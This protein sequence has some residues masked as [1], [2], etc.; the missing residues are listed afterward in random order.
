MSSERFSVS[1]EGY[2]AK[3][4][5][6]VYL[7]DAISQ[8]LDHKEDNPKV[9]PAKFFHDYFTSIHQGNHTLFR[10]YSFIRSTAHNRSSFTRTFW[11]CYKHIGKNGDLL[12]V[13]EYHSLLCL[14]CPDFPFDLVQK[15]ARIIL[16]DDAMDCLMSFSDFLYAFQLQFYYEEFL[17]DC[18]KIY[19][20]LMQATR[21]PRETVVVPSSSSSPRQKKQ[22]TPLPPPE[23]SPEGV[24]CLQFYE[25]LL[26][27]CS[28]TDCSH[29]KT[30]SLKDILHNSNRVSFYGFLMALAKNESVNACIGVLPTK[31]AIMD[32]T[33]P[34]H[35]VPI[36]TPRSKS[37][38]PVLGGRTPRHIKH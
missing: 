24:D 26:Q 35:I 6:L 27:L 37:A 5:V 23:Q 2:L 17:Q 3:H 29:P 31:A 16:M 1:A 8:L 38:K 15:T 10:E 32:D 33:D 25:S 18:Y 20:K 34:E 30:N 21:S 7:E 14:L 13:K 9:N 22:Q 36:V 4:Q 19:E 28:V 12:N 11:K